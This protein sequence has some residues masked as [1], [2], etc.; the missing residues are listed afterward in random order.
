MA[1]VLPLFN[2]EVCINV[3]QLVWSY[4]D[5]PQLRRLIRQTGSLSVRVRDWTLLAF[6]I[7]QKVE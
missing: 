3:P 7:L 5:G 4:G 1:I 2:N 6:K